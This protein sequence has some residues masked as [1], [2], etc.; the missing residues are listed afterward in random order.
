MYGIG[1]HAQAG[2]I[3]GLSARQRHAH[4]PTEAGTSLSDF[5]KLESRPSR[6]GVPLSLRDE[7]RFYIPSR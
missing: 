1:Q 3:A 7:D 4:Q 5:G 2:V 6:E